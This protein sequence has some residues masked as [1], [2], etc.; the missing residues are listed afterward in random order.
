MQT[1]AQIKRE[2]MAEEFNYQHT[3]SSSKDGCNRKQKKKK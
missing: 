3:I 2:L 1:E